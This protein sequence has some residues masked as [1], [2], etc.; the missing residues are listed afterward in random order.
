VRLWIV[1][2]KREAARFDG[3]GDRVRAVAFS[4]DGRQ[5]LSGG[6]D[7]TVRLWDLTGAMRAAPDSNPN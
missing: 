2:G 6:D 4:S 5:A 7:R 1:P 3:H